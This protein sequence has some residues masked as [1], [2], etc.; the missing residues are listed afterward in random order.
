MLELALV[1]VVRKAAKRDAVEREIIEALEAYGVAV[2]QLS[3]KGVPDLLCSYDGRWFLVEVKSAKGKLT[4]DQQE[5][6]D[7][8]AWVWIVRSK[9]D[10]DYIM[11]NL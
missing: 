3:Q 7:K 4:E 1:H 10:V 9:T 8:H 5:F 2:T 6:I 11:R